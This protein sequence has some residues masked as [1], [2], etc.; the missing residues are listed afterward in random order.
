MPGT[1]VVTPEPYRVE[2][3]APTVAEIRAL[4]RSAGWTD[5]P[6]D[7]AAVA[8]G[9]G[10]SLFGVVVTIAGET[11]ACARLVGD[12]GMYYYLQDLIVLPSHQGKGV[13]DIVM[14]EV[15]DYLEA[16]AP[17]NCFVGLFAAA[18]KGGFYERYGFRPR[19]GDEPGMALQWTPE[20]ARRTRPP[21]R[22]R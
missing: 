10:A 20:I 17:C 21:G 4:Y 14:R 13:G 18:G 22:T 15:V 8:R 7:D 5:I 9:L 16:H 1:E 19:A 6:A 2:P 12:G 3:R 11:V